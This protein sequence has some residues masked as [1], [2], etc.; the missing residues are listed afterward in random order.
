MAEGLIAIG[1]FLVVFIAI[2]FLDGLIKFVWK[3]T[4]QVLGVLAGIG[5][6]AAL[7][8]TVVAITI[9]IILA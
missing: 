6:A 3:N 8:T 2:K 9:F 7:I 4:V 1:I 5:G